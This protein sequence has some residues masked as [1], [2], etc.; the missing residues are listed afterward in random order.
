MEREKGTRDRLVVDVA[1]N[2]WFAGRPVG[3]GQYTD[4][5]LGALADIAPQDRVDLVRPGE[6]RTPNKL[7]FEQLDFP[8]AARA[9]DVAHVPYW[10]PPLYPSVPTVVTVHDLVPLV[11]REYRTEW[12]VRA[13][14]ALVAR[15]T[16][17]AA[18]VL[19]DS[20]HTAQDVIH[21]LGVDSARIRVIPL[22]VNMPAGA[23]VADRPA[24][25]RDGP[26]VIAGQ[27][28]PARYGLYLGGF[29]IRKN[30][31][32]LL[33][34]W[35]SVYAATRV[36]LVIAGE[37]P[38]LHDPLKPHPAELARQV[39]LPSA[40]LCLIGRFT[41]AEKPLLYAGAAV[42]AFP[43]RY[44]GFGLPA[45]E[46]MAC[47]TPVVAADATSLPEVVGDA[48][49][50]VEPNDVSGWVEALCTVLEDVD[51]ARQLTEAGRARAATLTWQRTAERTLAVYRRLCGGGSAAGGVS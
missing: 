48:G 22:G 41:D 15:A 19:A 47:G 16:R 46:A 45:L 27:A 25:S 39:G 37:L 5:L 21:W 33:A 31:A 32:T 20:E 26:L 40:A 29:D 11:L 17:R 23:M 3:S 12:K 10:A 51:K 24:E 34:A 9:A 35:R 50:L 43:S 28:L 14:T 42:F 44:E 8:R 4:H 13:Y 6:R 30:V 2:G 36:P 38:E 18:A 7:R 49:L 1:V